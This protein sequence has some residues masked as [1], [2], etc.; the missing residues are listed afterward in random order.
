MD[1]RVKGERE[2]E[3]AGPRLGLVLEVDGRREV[4]GG[5]AGEMKAKGTK[6]K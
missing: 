5:E 1:E 2:R 6:N 3:E 4:G